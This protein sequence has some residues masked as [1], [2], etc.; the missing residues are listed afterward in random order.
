[1][2]KL[3]R[4]AYKT[5]DRIIEIE[6]YLYII[7]MFLTKGEAIR[8]ILIFSG[9]FLW[10]VTLKQRE[11]R[12]I[13][14]QP[15]PLLFWGF[16]ATI[17]IAVVFS[18]DPVYSFYSLREV[19]LKSVIIF[20]LV[21]T[22]LSDEKRLKRFAGLTFFILVFTI[23]VGYY[24]YFAYDL[25]LMKPVTAIRRAWHARFA[26]DLN[27]LI[28]FTFILLLMTRNIKWR[29]VLLVTV[30]AGIL[31]VILST[32]RGGIAGSV[33]MALVW[34][35][36]LSGMKRNRLKLIASFFVLFL[37][38][39]SMA[40]SF[41]PELKR[42]FI[43]DKNEIISLN[44][45]TEI[46]GPLVAAAFQRPLFGWGYGPRI[47]IHD[48]PFENTPYK[49][50]PVNNDPAFRNPHNPFLRVFFHQGIAGLGFYLLLL[51]VATVT[52][53]RDVS[54]ANGFKRYMLIA[55]TGILTGTYFVNAIVENSELPD[56]AF[57]LALGLA[58]RYMKNEDSHNT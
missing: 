23:A 34:I 25:P 24:S 22:A 46:W 54:G 6:I 37:L 36:F 42:K 5:I 55:C 7:F 8:N 11:N 2:R 27:T 1:M 30:S 41:S 17:L 15:V 47:F 31:G 38:M 49:V 20:C 57:I 26:V 33:S 4:N 44:R 12:W 45:R 19:P 28:P 48:K 18:I 14:K 40:L 3:Y 9:F 50:A 53:W 21:S 16:T 39:F 58:V 51:I 52:L 35:F 29:I 13:L 10:L 56:L 43:G 32:S